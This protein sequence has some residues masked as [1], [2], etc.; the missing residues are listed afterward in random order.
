MEYRDDI[1]SSDSRDDLATMEEII[2]DVARERQL[3]VLDDEETLWRLKKA[4]AGSQ[5]RERAR[6][7][8]S[9]RFPQWRTLK[10]NPEPFGYQGAALQ[11]QTS[12]RDQGGRP[13]S[14]AASATAPISL[15]QLGV[16]EP[17][18]RTL[19]GMLSG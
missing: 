14:K 18:H 10:N 1:L 4:V 2:G 19:D 12:E 11:G 7:S 8:H 13:R 6:G 9:R 5:A 15:C 16:T 3:D 17:V